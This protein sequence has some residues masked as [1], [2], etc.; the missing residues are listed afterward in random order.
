MASSAGEFAGFKGLRLISGELKVMIGV[1]SQNL[2]FIENDAAIL[3]QVTLVQVTFVQVAIIVQVDY[4]PSVLLS[5]WDY[6]PS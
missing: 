1:G 6:S 3:V 5:K 2:Y 4:C